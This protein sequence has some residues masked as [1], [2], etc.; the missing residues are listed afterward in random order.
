MSRYDSFRQSQNESNSQNKRQYRRTSVAENANTGF[1][2][3]LETK[4]SY[5][6]LIDFYASRNH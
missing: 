3:A 2:Y 5:Y 4:V 6:S 1:P